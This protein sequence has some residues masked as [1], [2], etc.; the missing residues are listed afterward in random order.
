MSAG[1]SQASELHVRYDLVA[2]L[3]EAKADH[4]PESSA[5]RLLKQSEIATRFRKLPRAQARSAK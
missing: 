3:S 1:K 2:T 4:S 5:R